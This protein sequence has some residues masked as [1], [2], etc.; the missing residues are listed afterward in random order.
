MLSCMVLVVTTS[1]YTQ[2]ITYDES[3][4]HL[5]FGRK[6]MK[7][8]FNDEVGVLSPWTALNSSAG[9]LARRLS[10]GHIS[11]R[12]WL[13]ACRLPTVAFT[14]LLGYGIFVWARQLFGVPAGLLSLLLYIFCPQVLAHGGLA[15]TDMYSACFI[16][17]A[18]FFF[19][20]LLK[21][22][23]FA[24]LVLSAVTTA[25]ALVAKHSAL[26]LPL[27]FFALFLCSPQRILLRRRTGLLVCALLAYA[28][29][30]V[31]TINTAYVFNNTLLPL[32]SNLFYSHR[33]QELR[34]HAPGL[35]IPLPKAYVRSLDFGIFFN[36]TCQGHGPVY[37][38]GKLQKCGWP[39]Y[40]FVALLFKLPLAVMPLLALGT[41]VFIRDQGVPVFD[42]M[43]VLLVP[44]VYMA[45]LF[46]F[47]KNQVG[48]RNT[49]IILPFWYIIIGYIACFRPLWSRCRG[50]VFVS[51]LLAW[52]VASSLS[53]YPHYLAYFN[54]LI[55]KRTNMYKYL[56]DSNVDW[57]Q[58]EYYLKEYL[59]K[60]KGERVLVR[61][62][63]P[64]KGAVVVNINDLV[65][66]T[67]DV[68]RYRWLRERYT[69]VG[70]IAYS[71]LI[72][73]TRDQ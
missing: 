40:F 46:P 53:F 51:V 52:Y 62:D 26:W 58:S 41:V 66:V 36:E 67:S 14:V 4:F 59:A 11:Q 48:V 72:F 21:D 20:G 57:G 31:A 35:L 30:V 16:F 18:V 70:H 56:A 50:K 7:G 42:K 25:A 3:Q 8:D 5:G 32:G 49:L 9:V 63:G 65:G 10:H 64:V 54:E 22:P 43:S 17:F 39:Y 6:M 38:L 27:I 23:S 13:F 71:Y 37:L 60:H 12:N 24:R 15:T 68:Q 73:D 44:L 34:S 45:L 33:L 55:G 29:I 2:S 19:V 61:P 28:A 1:V 69:P 47:F